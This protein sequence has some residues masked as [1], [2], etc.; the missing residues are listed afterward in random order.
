VHL[1]LL[2]QGRRGEEKKKRRRRTK[3]RC[4]AVSEGKK[5]RCPPC[6]IIAEKKEEGG[7]LTSRD[8]DID[9]GKGISA[10]SF[11]FH[12]WICRKEGGGGKEKERKGTVPGDRDELRRRE[13]KEGRDP[14]KCLYS[15]HTRPEWRGKGRGEES[16]RVCIPQVPFQAKGEGR[17]EHGN[18]VS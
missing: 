1:T 17:K 6:L 8:V 13:K 16:C 12:S 14:E 11:V 10:T 4:S 15:C 18:E 7:E 9:E 5:Q 3:K 2:T